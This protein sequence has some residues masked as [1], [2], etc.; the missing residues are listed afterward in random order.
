L[1]E[2]ILSIRTWK[3]RNDIVGSSSAGDG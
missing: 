1:R 2:Y 3:S